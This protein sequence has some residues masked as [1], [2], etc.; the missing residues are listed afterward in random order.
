MNISHNSFTLTKYPRS[1]FVQCNQGIF[2]MI[3]ESSLPIGNSFLRILSLFQ[4]ILTHMTWG[5]EPGEL[6]GGAVV[7]Q[8]L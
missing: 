4:D 3:L 2:T 8:L 7:P 6:G 1:D 5:T